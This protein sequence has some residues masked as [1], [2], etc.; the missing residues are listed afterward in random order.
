MFAFLKRNHKESDAALKLYQA[1]VAQAREPAFYELYKVPDTIDG[2]FDLICL[3]VY[4]IMDRLYDEGRPGAKLA[5]RLF[6]AMFRDMDRSLREMGAGDLSVPKHV[7]R[8]MK[9]FNGRAMSY[10]AAIESDDYQD[11]IDGILRN[12]YGTLENP[13]AD[14]A[15]IMALYMYENADYLEGQSWEALAQGHIEFREVNNEAD[16]EERDHAVGMVA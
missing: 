15:K 11:L 7:K 14:Y 10:R 8:M 16:E 2:R 13:P 3:H 6:D 12:L 5:Q 1:A 4:L 9:G